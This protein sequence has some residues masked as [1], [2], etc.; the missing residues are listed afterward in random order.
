[1][2]RT[3]RTI[4]ITFP[5]CSKSWFTLFNLLPGLPGK[6]YTEYAS[7]RAL[8]NCQTNFYGCSRPDQDLGLHAYQNSTSIASIS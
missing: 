5:Y 3:G 4:A 1:M 2:S 7:S 8:P 6:P